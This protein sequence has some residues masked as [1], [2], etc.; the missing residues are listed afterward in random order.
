MHGKDGLH[1]RSCH[2]STRAEQHCLAQADADAACL[3]R[4]EATLLP[5]QHCQ[6]WPVFAA[7][8]SLQGKSGTSCSSSASVPQA[9]QRFVLVVEGSVRLQDRAGAADKQLQPDM[10]AFCPDAA[11]CRLHLSPDAA[12][13][14][15]E[16][17]QPLDDGI[18]A[19]GQKRSPQLQV[20]AIG[21]VPTLDTGMAPLLSIQCSHTP[22]AL[23][24]APAICWRAHEFGLQ[25]VRAT[26]RQ[27]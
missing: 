22:P 24:F 12:L 19:G 27:C 18:I 1:T 7:Q 20:G 23:D 25:I 6:A 16:R 4:S 8:A 21:E 11:A 15:F 13:L 2:C 5:S 14:V 10:F 26:R 9:L 3:W 17:V